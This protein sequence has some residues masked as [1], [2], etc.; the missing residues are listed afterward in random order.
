VD[1]APLADCAVPMYNEAEN[2]HP[3]ALNYVG[4]VLNIGGVRVY[5]AGD[6]ERFPEMKTFAA[7]VVMLPLGQ[8]FTMNMV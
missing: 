1:S 6:T 8:V 3:R 4:Y 2:N 5:H 7:D